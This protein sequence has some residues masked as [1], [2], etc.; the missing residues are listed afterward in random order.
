MACDATGQKPAYVAKG[1]SARK[2][3]DMV[4]GHQNTFRIPPKPNK[5][6]PTKAS[7]GWLRAGWLNPLFF[8]Y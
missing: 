1:R 2:V 5:A 6:T 3:K 4:R 7:P 8:L